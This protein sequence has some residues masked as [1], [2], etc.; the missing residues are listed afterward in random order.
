VRQGAHGT[1]CRS[2]QTWK[3]GNAESKRAFI[4]SVWKSGDQHV[5]LLRPRVD[6]PHQL[7]SLASDFLLELI[8]E[9]WSHA[10]ILPLADDGGD[11]DDPD[12]IRS[13]VRSRLGQSPA[14]ETASQFSLDP[15]RLARPV[16]ES[17]KRASPH[18]FR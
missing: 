2:L 12:S 15:S 10:V 14:R 6:D 11:T 1:R 18:S 9:S 13:G 5:D 3:V 17:C 4:L 7:V 8:G 16:N